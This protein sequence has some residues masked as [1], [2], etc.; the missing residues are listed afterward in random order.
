MSRRYNCHDNAPVE[1]FF[2]LLK[3]E[4]IKRRIYPT[5]DATRADVFDHIERFHKP[6]R[7]HSSRNDVPHVEF[8]RRYA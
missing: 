2:G 5:K 6:K 3:L 4:R 8:D 1:R 7:M